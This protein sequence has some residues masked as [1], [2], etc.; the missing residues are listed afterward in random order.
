[1]NRRF[2]G[3][4][5][6]DKVFAIRAHGAFPSALDLPARTTELRCYGYISAHNVSLGTSASL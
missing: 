6:V 2:Y 3:Q 4:F 5:G 1:M